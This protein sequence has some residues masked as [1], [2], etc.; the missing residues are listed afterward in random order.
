VLTAE[1]VGRRDPLDATRA[2]FVSLALSLLFALVAGVLVV[3][4]APQ[5]GRAY[6]ADAPLAA[7]VAAS[8]WLTALVMPPDAGQVVVAGSLRARGDNWFPTASHLLAYALVMPVLGLWLAEHREQGV[9]GLLVAILSA[10]LLS[11]AV[12]GVRLWAVRKA[13][14]RVEAT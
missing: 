5:V 7:Q 4:F 13:L 8:L 3:S 14:P 9:N 1:A 6:T 12:L 10:S 2:G 11:C